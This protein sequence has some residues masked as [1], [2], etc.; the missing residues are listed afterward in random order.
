MESV[1][2]ISP[3]TLS[4][5]DLLWQ[6]MWNKDK[7]TFAVS[8]RRFVRCAPSNWGCIENAPCRC[9]L[10]WKKNR[11][12]SCL[13]ISELISAQMPRTP[14]SVAGCATWFVPT[15]RSCPCAAMKLT[16]FVFMSI[17]AA[18]PAAGAAG[19]ILRTAF[20]IKSNLFVFRC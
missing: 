12:I 2:T 3:S 14:V 17:R 11:A 1:G 18:N 10:V 19:A 16:S 7:C 9:P 8:A 13:C 5:K 20:W 6:I 15:G 4:V